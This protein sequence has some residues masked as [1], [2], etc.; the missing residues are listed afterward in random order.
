MK[1]VIISDTHMPRKA[2]KLPTMLLQELSEADH[3]IHAGDVTGMELLKS[4]TTFAP[5]TAVSGNVD[6]EHVKKMLPKKAQLLFDGVS[7]GIVHGHEGKGRT[8][9]E[10][11]WRSFEQDVPDIIIFGHSHIP[12]HEIFEQ[13]VLFNPGSPTDKRRQ[14]QFSFGVLA[15]ENRHAELKTIYF[16]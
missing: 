15:I 9:K 12:H 4:L 10:R 6:E 16:D 8:T 11:A 7:I 2:P 14:K 13:T 5:V 1:I 3:I